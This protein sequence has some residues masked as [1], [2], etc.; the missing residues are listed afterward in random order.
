[1]EAQTY[2]RYFGRKRT[3]TVEWQEMLSTYEIEMF[4]VDPHKFMGIDAA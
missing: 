2:S 1:M 3:M 4:R